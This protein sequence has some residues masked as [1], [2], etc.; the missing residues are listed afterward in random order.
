VSH[1]FGPGHGRR[2]AETVAQAMFAA[3][4]A[5]LLVG[6]AARQMAG[7]GTEPLAVTGDLLVGVMWMAVAVALWPRRRTRKSAALSAAFSV[8]WLLG[9]LDPALLFVHR[10]PLAHVLL[11]YPKG[12]LGSVPARVAVTAAYIDGI[13]A[14][15]AGG[16]EWT[17][18]FAAGL[19]AAASVRSLTA[20]GAV[21]R[22]RVVPLA[23]AWA[24]G[25]VLATG[26]S[27]RLAGEEADVLVAYEVVLVVAGVAVAADLRAARWSHGSITGL[28]VD[29]GERPV[30][31]V[32]RDRLARAVGDPTLKVAYL[33][34]GTSPPVDEH[35]EP[36]ELPSAASTRVVTPVDLAGQPL[37]LLIH[38]PAVLADRPL[39]D[40]A[41]SALSVAVANAQLQS[42]VRA[43]VA[44]VEAST[45][46][47][48]DAAD[49]ERRR[50]G[51]DLRAQVDPLL[52]QAAEELQAASAEADLLARVDDVRHQLFR[53]AAGLDPLV[54]HE[55][56]LGPALRELAQHAGIPVSVFVPTDRLPSSV[57]TCVWFTCSEAM[58]NALK[59]AHASRLEI[60]VRRRGDVLHVEVAD[61]GVGGADPGRGSGLRRLAER[62]QSAGGRLAIQSPRGRG[63]RIAAEIDLRARA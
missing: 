22:S 58:A 57:E 39:I 16:P 35:G 47:L 32:V 61:D 23:A 25:A 45:R 59:H 3:A 17:L 62:V 27:A 53:L 63:T 37:A 28:V 34:D 36:V 44:D 48:L 60:A 42:E 19:V 1:W 38:D 51:S 20:T 50:L 8:T 41:A 21:R 30:G 9:S 18:A 14:G 55:R 13:L 4:L 33:L 31:G 43:S 15:V 26:A 7:A 40:G 29:L 10:G 2:R 5:A 46:R 52:Q 12:R 24:V 11:A 56:G 49:G 54:L 6:A